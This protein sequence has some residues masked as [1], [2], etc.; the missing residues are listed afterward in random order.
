MSETV[1][2]S[3]SPT[4]SRSNTVRL[5]TAQALV[6]FLAGLRAEGMLTIARGERSD[7]NSGRPGESSRSP[8]PC[9]H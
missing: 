4:L 6:R 2:I 3:K 7:R 1:T 9:C 8:I 5:T